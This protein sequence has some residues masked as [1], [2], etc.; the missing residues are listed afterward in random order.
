MGL[1]DHISTQKAERTISDE[2]AEGA[3]DVVG[4]FVKSI[5]LLSQY[6]ATPL[7]DD[8]MPYHERARGLVKASF[9]TAKFC[10]LGIPPNDYNG[11][12]GNRP[13]TSPKKS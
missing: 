6:W 1:E 4:A 11:E 2:I 7:T 10:C 5:S 13:S 9:E 8:T 12:Q 3:R